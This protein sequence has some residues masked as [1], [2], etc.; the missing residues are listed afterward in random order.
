MTTPGE[1]PIPLRMKKSYQSAARGQRAG[2]RQRRRLPAR[3]IESRAPVPDAQRKAPSGRLTSRR[4]NGVWFEIERYPATIISRRSC[5]GERF[6][7]WAD[8]AS[9]R[10]RR[11]R[12]R[13]GWRQSGLPRGTCGRIRPRHIRATGISPPVAAARPGADGQLAILVMHVDRV[14]A[15]AWRIG[16]QHQLVGQFDNVD[17]GTIVPL[18]AV[19]LLLR[20]F[21]LL[22]APAL[23]ARLPD[24]RSRCAEWL[25]VSWFHLLDRISWSI[26]APWFSAGARTGARW[27]DSDDSGPGPCDQ[28]PPLTWILRGRAEAALG[29][30][31]SSTPSRSVAS[32]AAGST[33]YGNR[34]VRA[35]SPTPRSRR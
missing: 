29:S 12:P 19:R 8:G 28:L 14:A 15:R 16:K 2:Q 17:I 27:L 33:S 10:R 13:S 25:G 32:T 18:V 21:G 11:I 1:T 30:L 23:F 3:A 35:N 7:P 22:I 34:N 5:A 4:P 6:R 9:A 20:R 31:S 26:L 24:W